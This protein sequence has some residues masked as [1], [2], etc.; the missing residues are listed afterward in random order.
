MMIHHGR[1][2]RYHGNVTLG[3]PIIIITIII[4]IHHHHENLTLG[5]SHSD[6]HH[7]HHANF[8]LGRT[9]H[10]R[11]HQSTHSRLQSKRDVSQSQMR[12]QSI[13]VSCVIIIIIIMMFVG[14]CIFK[15]DELFKE[16]Q[17]KRVHV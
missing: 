14:C 16:E 12:M 4:M 10:H 5:T 17:P 8:T 13:T 9:H 2:H 3:H 15:A 6:H 7:H 11:H 1:H